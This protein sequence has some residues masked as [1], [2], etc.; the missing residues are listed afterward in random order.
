MARCRLHLATSPSR[1]ST[2][3]P[4][5][6][7]RSS[8]TM[9][10]NL[11]SIAVNCVAPVSPR[12]ELMQPPLTMT[13][14]K[15]LDVTCQCGFSAGCSRAWLTGTPGVLSSS[16]MRLT[17]AFMARPLRQGVSYH[18]R[19]SPPLQTESGSLQEVTSSTPPMPR[20]AASSWQLTAPAR[21]DVC[22]LQR[23]TPPCQAG[24]L[25]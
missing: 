23:A 21:L 5:R 10:M 2:R 18:T 15:V 3:S 11:P 16:G 12:G 4:C 14:S 1:P 19:F 17:S 13:M 8:S 9:E 7:S 25:S 24:T 20:A 22:A 6:S